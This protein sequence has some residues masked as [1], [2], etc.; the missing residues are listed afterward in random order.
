[1]EV[2]DARWLPA[3]EEVSRKLKKLLPEAHPDI[4]PLKDFALESSEA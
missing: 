1:M 4:E 2:A 3:L